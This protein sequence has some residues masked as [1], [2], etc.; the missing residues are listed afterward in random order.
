MLPYDRDEKKLEKLLERLFEDDDLED[1]E[2]LGGPGPKP[3]S[4]CCS[5]SYGSY[6]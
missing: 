5:L 4:D 6:S 2:V 3:F 1:V